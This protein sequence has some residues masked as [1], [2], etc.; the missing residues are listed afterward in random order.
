MCLF[1]TDSS[2]FRLARRV[3]AFLERRHADTAIRL[4]EPLAFNAIL[5][6]RI[7][8]LRHHVGHLFRRERRTDHAAEMRARCPRALLAAE[9]DLIPLRAVFTDTDHTDVADVMMTPTLD[10]HPEVQPQSPD[11]RPKPN[12]PQPRS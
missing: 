4:D 8:H 9:R 5:N 6:E 2:M 3:H 1:L 7:D 12:S 10:T 11:F